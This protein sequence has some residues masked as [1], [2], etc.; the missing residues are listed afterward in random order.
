MTYLSHKSSKCDI[1]FPIVN[2]SQNS[3]EYCHKDTGETFYGVA[4]KGA[5]SFYLFNSEEDFFS[6]K[7]NCKLFRYSSLATRAT[8]MFPIASV[9]EQRGLIYFWDSEIEKWE[10][11]GLKLDALCIPE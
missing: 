7:L 9:N 10:T 1:P 11:K 4:I 2:L 5:R 6:P 3:N 8:G